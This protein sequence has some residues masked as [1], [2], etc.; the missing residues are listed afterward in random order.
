MRIAFLNRSVVRRVGDLEW[1][2]KNGR[3]VSVSDPLLVG[4]L[5]TH[6]GFSIAEDEPLL[7]VMSV[8]EAGLLAIDGGVTDIT[9]LANLKSATVKVMAKKMGI[10]GKVV[11]GWVDTAS[12][13]L[14]EITKEEAGKTAVKDDGGET[15]VSTTAE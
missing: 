6:D 9:T 3:V 13:V 2:D 14:L 10:A 11:L 15:A 12:R 8:D 5:L 4:E 1:S 7:Q